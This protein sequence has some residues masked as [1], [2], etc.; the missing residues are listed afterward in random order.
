MYVC[1]YVRTYMYYCNCC[2]YYHHYYHYY[3]CY[4]ST[5]MY[6]RIIGICPCI[7][8]LCPDFL[9]GLK[10]EGSDTALRGLK[11]PAYSHSH[12]PGEPRHAKMNIANRNPKPSAL[13]PSTYMYI[14]ICTYIYMY[15]CLSLSLSRSLYVYTYVCVHI[16]PGARIYIYICMYICMYLYVSVHSCTSNC[17]PSALT[18]TTTSWLRAHYLHG[19]TEE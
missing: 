7:Y 3:R 17:I 19:T 1:T 18:H 8:H 2:Y 16:Y 9:Q 10:A 6:T 15:I 4:N 5:Y 14:H 11:G 13:N 12:L